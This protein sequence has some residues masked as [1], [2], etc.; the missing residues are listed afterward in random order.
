MS[1]TVRI[2]D[3]T[4]VIR[5]PRRDEVVL[6]AVGGDRFVG[7]LGAVTFTRSATGGIDGL[8]GSSCRLRHLRAERVDLSRQ[9]PAISTSAPVRP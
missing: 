7:S 3:N 9:P 6:E 1:Y 8:R 2:A 4:L 5:W